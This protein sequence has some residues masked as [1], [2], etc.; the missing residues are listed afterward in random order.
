MWPLK[1]QTR[2]GV[3]VATPLAFLTGMLLWVHVLAAPQSRDPL[4]GAWYMGDGL[5]VNITIH[6]R[7]DSTYSAEWFGCLGRYGR[8]AGSWTL[9]DSVVELAPTLEEDMLKGF[10]RRLELESGEKPKHLFRL[11]LGSDG[12][13]S[14]DDGDPFD[15]RPDLDSVVPRDW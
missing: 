6:F 12:A 14:R 8:A 7:P 10:L 1:K 13:W 3:P 15:R 9:S 4:S 5:G 11:V 2:C